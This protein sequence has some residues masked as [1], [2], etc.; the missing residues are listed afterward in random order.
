MEESEQVQPQLTA[1]RRWVANFRKVNPAS[2]PGSQVADVSLEAHV[3]QTT[4]GLETYS[5]PW[6][7]S[8]VAHLLRRTLFGIKKSELTHFKALSLENAVSELLQTSPAPAPPVNDYNSAADNINDP[9]VAFGETWTEAPFSGD[10]ETYRVISLK[11]WQIKTMLHQEPVIQEKM[12][13]FWHNL[14]VT[15]SWGIFIGKMSYRYFEL[16]RSN[17]L[18]NYKTLIRAIT[19]DP[20]M[21]LYLNGAA[22]NKFAPD[23]NYGR[24]LQEL[25]CIGK[26]P[27][28]KYSES[29]VQAAA[30]VLTGWTLNWETYTST[31]TFQAF[32]NPDLHDTSDKQF[33][34][35]YGGAIIKG[36]TGQDGAA[37]LDE[38]L[39]IILG[40]EECARYICRRLYIFFVSSTIDEAT[41]KAV[42]EPL[43]VLFRNSKYEILP[44]LNL[45]FK[46]AH[47]YDALTIGALIK[48]PLDHLLGTWRTLG[49]ARPAHNDLATSY[50]IHSNMLWRMAG[51]GLE[52]AD[53]PSVA[54]WQ[55]YYQAPQFDKAWIATDTITLR[56]LTTDSLLFFGFWVSQSLQIK[57]DVLAFAKA[58]DDPGNPVALLRE[59]AQLFLG[60]ALS[61]TTVHNLKTVLLSGQQDDGYWT[62]A[63]RTWL[64]DPENEMKR[65]TVEYRL[66][67]TFQRLLQLGEYHLM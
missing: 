38:L 20:A 43:A 50:Q 22:N 45:L 6:T 64:N 60:L 31:G 3:R 8:Q 10:Y 48:S 11:S 53:P 58:L 7:E 33:S 5:G 47:F 32:F 30:R 39:D 51:M 14:L 37:E 36:K 57:A 59:S 40:N 1:H 29:D 13:F 63:W 19:L 65:L 42:I 2:L 62:A 26:G 25:F 49:V 15:Q 18:G 66:Q 56:A 23:E 12:T 17:A 35:F 9:H 54:G 46:S 52:I 21:L 27:G 55:A 4:A 61:D 24:E 67:L 28:S 34:A 16:L 41:E 44:V